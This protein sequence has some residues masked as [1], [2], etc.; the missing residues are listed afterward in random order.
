M[1]SIYDLRAFKLIPSKLQ[2]VEAAIQH[3]L[4]GDFE[5][6]LDQHC[7]VPP[8][9]PE[10]LFWAWFDRHF[11][12]GTPSYTDIKCKWDADCAR[13]LR[14]WLRFRGE[15]CTTP[16]IWSIDE[17]MHELL[18]TDEHKKWKLTRKLLKTYKLKVR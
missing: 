15:H 18:D 1:T 11:P 5:Y 13:L 7:P 14:K 4:D 6:L 2:M 8:P 16:D 12:T 17:Q 10:E 9:L 3:I